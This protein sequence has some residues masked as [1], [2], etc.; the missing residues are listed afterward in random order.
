M[1]Q[2]R[3]RHALSD[4]ERADQLLAVKERQRRAWSLQRRRS[5]HP[6]DGSVCRNDG[7]TGHV[8][9]LGKVGECRADARRGGPGRERRLAE[10]AKH[11]VAGHRPGAAA[12]EPAP[13]ARSQG[14]VR[15]GDGDQGEDHEV[16]SV[17]AEHVGAEQ[18]DAEQGDDE[19]AHRRA[20]GHG[21]P[22]RPCRHRAA[23]EDPGREDR[24]G[25]AH[26]G[27]GDERG[28]D[29]ALGLADLGE[30]PEAGA[31]PG[32]GN[33]RQRRTELAPAQG[34]AIGD[35]HRDDQ[36]PGAQPDRG[37]PHGDPRPAEQRARDRTQLQVRR[38]HGN[39]GSAVHDVGD[40]EH[41]EDGV[42]RRDHRLLVAGRVTV[43]RNLEREVGE[44]GQG[45]GGHQLLD[46][47]REGLD[48]RRSRQ[49]LDDDAAA[50]GREEERE[51]CEHASGRQPRTQLDGEPEPDG[52]QRGQGLRQHLE[53]FRDVQLGQC[54]GLRRKPV[55]HVHRRPLRT[56][57]VD[58]RR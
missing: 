33:R 35:T 13:E 53:P 54:L 52:Q 58:I 27:Q 45:Q 56:R 9:R 43:G 17:Q 25:R 36:P 26:D 12:G 38:R 39:R 21:G 31:E 46:P 51:P 4:T 8:E 48:V 16:R 6:D 42:D 5:L 2:R 32:D 50:P 47:A 11:P 3:S 23:E 10:R 34:P 49:P 15:G 14:A 19:D 41:H 20:A 1:V 57:S 7:D 29:P 40:G 28:P 18:L 37:K 44:T 55:R 24:V 30:E 22:E